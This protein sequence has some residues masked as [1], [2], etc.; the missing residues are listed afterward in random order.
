MNELFLNRRHAT[1]NLHFI[2]EIYFKN[3]RL[4]YIIML[5]LTVEVLTRLLKWSRH[6]IYP[7]HTK[8]EQ[9]NILLL[10]YIIINIIFTITI[11]IITLIYN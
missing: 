10:I 4:G 5:S 3:Y 11:I 9:E 2:L 8:K 7:C 6:V 1:Q